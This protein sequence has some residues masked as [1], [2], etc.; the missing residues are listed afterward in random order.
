[1]SASEV[2]KTGEPGK[3]SS[4][5]VGGALSALNGVRAQW[6]S[7]A[8]ATLVSSAEASWKKL[9]FP[10]T[11]VESWKYTN[12]DPLASGSFSPVV[13]PGAVSKDDV[14][15]FV[16]KDTNPLLC[17]L[18]DGVFSSELSSNESIEGVTISS[19]RALS[20]G[21]QEA[22]AAKLGSTQVHSKEPFAALATAL[23]Q[24]GVV[25]SVARGVAAKRPIQVISLASKSASNSVITPRLFIELGELAELSVIE[26]HGCV[27][28][29]NYLSLPVI[30]SVV[31]DSARL[32]LTKI[33]LDDVTAYHVAHAVTEQGRASFTKALVF[34]FGGKLVRNSA[35]IELKGSSSEATIN[36]LSILGGSQ[37]VD[38]TTSIHHIEPSCE[39][40][41]LFKGVYADESRGVF[42]GTIV[43]ESEAQKTNAFQSNQTLLL[44][45][46]ASIDT[47]P[48]LKI[49]A[50]DVKCTH[51]ATIGQLD[52]TALYYLRSRGLDLAEAKRCLV[53][54]FTGEVV[55]SL[56]DA[57]LEAFVGEIVGATLEKLQSA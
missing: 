3:S 53:K 11:K 21:S 34:S 42:S 45:P 19:I 37:H 31:A 9:L 30:E 22:L 55:S 57:P 54:A 50:D 28:A 33:A 51:G 20:A 44:S 48:Q 43:V 27:G 15:R 32:T 35:D 38:N 56:N 26:T 16:V 25:I 41:E 24:D 1:M 39:S 49:W 52:E 5:W 12:A 10:T 13:S 36:G 7:P 47:R 17:V 46:T 29:Q 23:L 6:S 18:V 40:R 4:S 14:A 2:A 8:L